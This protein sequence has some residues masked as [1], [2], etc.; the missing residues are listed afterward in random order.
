MLTLFLVKT[1]I[2]CLSRIFA[3]ILVFKKHH[4]KTVFSFIAEFFGALL[5]LVPRVN[6]SLVPL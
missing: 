1:F 5:N 2:F 6:D 4:S 3:L